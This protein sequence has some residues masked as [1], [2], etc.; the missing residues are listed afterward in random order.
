MTKVQNPIIGRAKGSA[1]GMTFSKNSDQNVMRAK[2]FEVNNPKTQAQTT[3]RN[4]FKQVQQIAASVTPAQLRSL[5]GVKPKKMSRRNALTKQI[6]AAYSVDGTTKSVDFSKLLAIGNG[7]KVTTPIEI[8]QD[9]TTEGKVYNISMFG[10]KANENTTLILVGFDTDNK[11]I[12]LINTGLT[13]AD[14]DNDTLS[15]GYG[16]MDFENGFVYATC[17][18]NGKRVLNQAY[19]SFIIKTRGEK[20]GQQN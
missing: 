1:G 8:V 11:R 3:Q 9:S 4:F 2:A 10:T 7:E 18:T 19:G 12:H 17:P 13:L 15:G 14:I 20:I 5:F 6:A 16:P